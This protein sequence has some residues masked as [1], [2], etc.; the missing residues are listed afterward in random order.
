[1]ASGVIV[2]FVCLSH[3]SSGLLQKILDL[4]LVL[5]YSGHGWTAASCGRPRTFLFADQRIPDHLFRLEMVVSCGIIGV[6]DSLIPFR[7]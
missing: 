7:L 6:I 4:I 1:M 5:I 3:V 2:T